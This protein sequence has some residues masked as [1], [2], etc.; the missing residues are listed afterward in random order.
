MLLSLVDIVRCPA[1]HEESALV[2]SVESWQEQRIWTG[3][4]G[5]PI[6]HGRYEIRE[7]VVHFGSSEAASNDEPG[8]DVDAFRLAAQ[9]GLTEPG[10]VILLMGRYATAHQEL[11]ESADVTCILLEAGRSRAQLAVNF[12]GVRRLPLA[13]GVLRG[14]A[15]DTDGAIGFADVARCLRPRGRLVMPSSGSAPEGT[16]VLAEDAEETVAEVAD[17][18][19]RVTLTRTRTK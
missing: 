5:C 14:A 2:L 19:T 11:V 18:V 17:Q 3:T 7:G 13:D 15:M 10:G 6:C 12:T 16:K 4:L 1:P 8:E 9:L